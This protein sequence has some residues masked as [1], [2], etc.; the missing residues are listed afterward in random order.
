MVDIETI[1]NI[2]KDNALELYDTEIANEG[3]NR[4]F[5]IYITS[6]EGV[7]LDQCGKISSI[8]SPIL[9]LN[10]PM[11]GAYVLEVSS[12][13]IERNL[14]KPEHFSGS[15]GENVKIKLTNTDKIIGKLIAFDGKILEI[16][17]D[18]KAVQVDIADIDK[19]RTYYKW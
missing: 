5:R 3:G 17:E 7:T 6:P 9:D 15:I 13:G 4:I 16:E 2:L 8:L 12:P 14:K 19:A 18:G 1:K 10:P 11:N